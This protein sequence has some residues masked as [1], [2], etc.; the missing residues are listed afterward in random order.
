[1]ERSPMRQAKKQSEQTDPAA[2]EEI[3]GMYKAA[4]FSFAYYLTRDRSEA[5][6]LYQEAWLRIA[7]R[8]FSGINRDGLKA[9]IFTVVSNLYKDS[10]RKRRI[11]RL[12]LARVGRS[13]DAGDYG[14]EVFGGHPQETPGKSGLTDLGQ[15]IAEALARLPERQRRV[16][17]LKEV[18]GLK[19]AEISQILGLPLGT[20]KSL[21]HRAVRRLRRSL[22]EYN[23]KREAWKCDVKT[24]SV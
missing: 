7:R 8:G 17:V 4:V 6:D 5:E 15:D 2:F 10:L 9:W 19:Q 11:R 18:A 14:T 22:T 3:Y 20:V 24:L 12:F 23:P 13:G 21:M 1:M 16:F